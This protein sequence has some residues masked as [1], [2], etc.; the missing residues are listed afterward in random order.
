MSYKV[1]VAA[2]MVI[3]IFDG[4]NV[5]VSIHV[6]RDVTNNFNEN[7]ILGRAGFG[8][9]YKGE[10]RNATKIAVKRMEYGA[11]GKREWTNFKPKLQY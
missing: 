2:I 7:N 9:V 10:L 11:M 3:Y 5:A 4:G 6:L 8:I 1:N